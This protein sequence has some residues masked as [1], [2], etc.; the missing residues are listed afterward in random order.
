M[1]EDQHRRCQRT[2]VFM[3]RPSCQQQRGPERIIEEQKLDLPWKMPGWR[4]HP[5]IW[6]DTI[7]T[8]N[9]L[10]A[11]RYRSRRKKRMTNIRIVLWTIWRIKGTTRTVLCQ[12][13]YGLVQF[14]L[15][16]SFLRDFWITKRG[17]KKGTTREGGSFF[18]ISRKY[19]CV[20]TSYGVVK[21]DDAKCCYRCALSQ[22]TEQKIH[23]KP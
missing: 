17:R 15:K 4:L 22:S 8:L 7:A 19:I 13:N 20:K 11:Q 14:D 16:K 23:I 3:E 5:Q 18:G 12:W 1:D 6:P 21:L 2:K 9:L 10:K